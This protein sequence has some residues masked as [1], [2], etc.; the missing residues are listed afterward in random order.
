M[1]NVDERKLMNSKLRCLF[2]DDEA[3]T[4]KQVII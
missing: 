2:I 3:L 4:S 1:K